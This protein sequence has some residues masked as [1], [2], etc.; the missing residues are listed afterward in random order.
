MYLHSC[1]HGGRAHRLANSSH[2]FHSRWN[3]D[4]TG[5]DD[6]KSCLFSPRGSSFA[7]QRWNETDHNDCHCLQIPYI[8]ITNCHLSVIAK[9]SVSMELGHM[10]KGMRQTENSIRFPHRV[11]ARLQPLSHSIMNQQNDNR[12]FLLSSRFSLKHIAPPLPSSP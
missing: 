1:G 7:Y 12:E 8:L 3:E 5:L 9:P 10:T 6:V 4:G 2:T 11:I